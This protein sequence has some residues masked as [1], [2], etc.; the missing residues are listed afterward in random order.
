M[1]VDSHCHLNFLDDPSVRL[2]AARERGVSAFVCI[3]V[4]V[5]GID[6]VLDLAG[7]HDDV[8]AT[9]GQHPDAA[10]ADL[11]WLEARLAQPR[12]VAAGEMGLDYF[13]ASEPELRRRQLDCFDAQ[14]SLAAT[15]GLPVVVHTRAAEADTLDRLRAHRGVGGVL[16]C[17]TE[18]WDMA[19]AALDLGF[20]VSISGIVTF[21]NADNVRAVARRVPDDR[22]LIET[23]SPWLAPVPHRGQPN[24]PAFL[25]DT[26]AF[27]ADLRGQS[28]ADLAGHTGANFRRLFLA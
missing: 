9:V 25:V 28:V 24:E 7:R 5:A 10:G 26:A 21:R 8:W 14:L 15:R 6:D 2:A 18:S 4:D 23:D 17:F 12:V 13:H 19:S 1:L 27:L 3:G 16:H 11:D 20:Y 22:L